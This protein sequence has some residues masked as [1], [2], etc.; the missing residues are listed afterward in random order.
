MM[1]PTSPIL[2]G[3][4]RAAHTA[5]YGVMGSATV[6]LLFI[7]VTGDLMIALWAVAPL[8]AIE[9]AVFVLSGLK[10]PM[11][12]LVDHFAGRS[13]QVADTYLPESFT[14]HTLAIFGP[15]LAVASMLVAARWAGLL[16]GSTS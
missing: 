3:V 12:G 7:G 10:C 11:T 6:T 15:I 9:I 2:L 5:I 8:L 13:S 1:T 16:G 14:R 4:A